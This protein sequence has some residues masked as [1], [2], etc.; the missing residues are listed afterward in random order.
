MTYAPHALLRFGGR[1]FDT[2]EWSCSLRI[3]T[4]SNDATVASWVAAL[5]EIPSGTPTELS[6]TIRGYV[7][8]WFLRAGSGIANVARLD[9]VS[10]NAIG[11]DGLYADG[12]NPHTYEYAPGDAPTGPVNATALPQ[13]TVC[14]SLRTAVTRGAGT[15]GR[16]YPPT[17][18]QTSATG[19]VGSTV[20]EGMAASA[21][22][23]LEDIGSI[24]ELALPGQP[25][26][27]VVSDIGSPGPARIV[28]SVKVGNVFDTQRR[29]RAQL[30]EVYVTVP[31]DTDA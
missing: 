29:R 19:R 15:H 12:G 17:T 24:E 18:I 16:F 20:A 4:D 1:W 30:E 13:V 21:A 26:V 31:V 3:I 27:A 7:E 2:E 6:E 11:P 28:T 8:D 23:L 5:T 25:R 14:V 22:E 10:L 9:Y